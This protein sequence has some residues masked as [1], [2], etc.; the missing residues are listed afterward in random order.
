MRVSCVCHIEKKTD[1]FGRI[2]KEKTL[3][4]QGFLLFF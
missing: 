2:K 4:K 3:E 1:A